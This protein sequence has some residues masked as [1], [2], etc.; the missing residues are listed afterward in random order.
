[1]EKLD[2]LKAI[3]LHITR[4]LELQELIASRNAGGGDTGDEQISAAY[5]ELNDKIQSLK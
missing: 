5:K 1:M 4:T 3:L 2:D